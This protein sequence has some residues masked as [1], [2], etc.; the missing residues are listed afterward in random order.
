LAQLL[1]L[2]F[3]VLD[4]LNPITLSKKVI[5]TEN[6][7][8][9]TPKVKKTATIPAAD[10]DF[11]KVAKDVSAKWMATPTIVLNWIT[12]A[13]F[14]ATVT[15]YNIVLDARNQAGSTRPQ[16]TKALEIINAKIDDSIAYVKGYIIDKYKKEAAGSYYAAFGFV[17]KNKTYALPKDQNSRSTALELMK[18]AINTHGFG[19]KE[20]G[21]TFWTAVKTE[22][23]NLLDQAK[24]TDTTVAAK[25]GDKKVL[26]A[27]VTKTIN[28][29]IA[30]IKA[31]YPDTYK[32]ELRTWGFH[33]E[34]Y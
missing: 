23:D 25:V 16:V 14:E 12:A 6:T 32:T 20:Y 11:G 2:I 19:A 5:M 30:I 28:A 15:E 29:I 10:V 13:E 24:G 17:F 34:K 3:K 27:T 4:K 33:K 18:T 9:A 1:I 31:N 21:T 7:T 8:P 22:F 26:K